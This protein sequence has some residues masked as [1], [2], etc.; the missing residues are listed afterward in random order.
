MAPAIVGVA[1]VLFVEI[2]L[3]AVL[4]VVDILQTSRAVPIPS[5]RMTPNIKKNM[6]ICGPVILRI[7]LL[8]A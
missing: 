7:P 6:V 8:L 4:H 1:V 3:K 5:A 2:A